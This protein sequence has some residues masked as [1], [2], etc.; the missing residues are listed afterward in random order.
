MRKSV[1]LIVFAFILLVG[2]SP[3]LA[4]QTAIKTYDLS[5]SVTE[6]GTTTA[7]GT[8]VSGSTTV[9]GGGASPFILSGQDYVRSDGLSVI[10]DVRYLT[11]GNGM[12]WIT[13]LTVSQ[14]Q[15]GASGDYSGNTF[16][17][18][19]KGIRDGGDWNVAEMVPI[20]PVLAINGATKYGI[21]FVL[22]P[23]AEYRFY[24]ISC[25]ATPYDQAKGTVEIGLPGVGFDSRAAFA[26]SVVSGATIDTTGVSTFTAGSMGAIPDGCRYVEVMAISGGSVY[27]TIDG[28]TTPQRT[29][30][31]VGFYANV[32]Q[33]IPLT[34]YAAQNFK[35]VC[36][37]TTTKL[38]WVFYNRDP[39]K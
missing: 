37:A 20:T 25:G 8:Y 36:G 23:M 2:I 10:K 33:A 26:I 6:S 35:L 34:R 16:Y 15:Q 18:A 30:A 12:V 24:F 27:Y 21:P 28:L 32:G 3:V 4:V 1:F 19:A 31:G 7:A 13:D 22:E 29:G 39:W 9:V 11:S 5:L 17:F 14:A 38:H